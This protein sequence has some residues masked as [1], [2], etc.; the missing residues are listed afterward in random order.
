MRL[1]HKKGGLGFE[2]RPGKETSAWEPPDTIEGLARGH[3][4]FELP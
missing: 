3:P 1:N 4:V 2:T